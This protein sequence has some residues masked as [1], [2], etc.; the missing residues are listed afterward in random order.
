MLCPK[1]ISGPQFAISYFESFSYEKSLMNSSVNQSLM[2][3]S[4]LPIVSNKCVY[5][6]FIGLDSGENKNYQHTLK[7]RELLWCYFYSIKVKLIL[8]LNID[9]YYEQI[10]LI[11]Q[12]CPILCDPMH[13]SSPGYSVPG[14]LQARILQWVAVPFPRGSSRPRDQMRV[15]CTAGR[16]FTTWA[17]RETPRFYWTMCFKNLDIVACLIL[18]TA[19]LVGD[20]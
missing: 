8:L 19:L 16:F 13:C 18:R 10:L 20:S 9:I 11:A 12:L 4:L 2:N 14:I 17:T 3:W 1:I 5:K 15:S 6:I 7:K